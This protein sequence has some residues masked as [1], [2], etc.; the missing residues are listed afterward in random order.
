M[1]EEKRSSLK[2]SR[3][4][5]DLVAIGVGFVW[6]GFAG[7]VL[8]TGYFYDDLALLITDASLY[9]KL[10]DISTILLLLFGLLLIVSPLH[11]KFFGSI[12]TVFS[13]F[14]I[15][16]DIYLCTKEPLP[17]Y[18]SLRAHV[19]TKSIFF[20]SLLLPPLLTLLYSFRNTADQGKKMH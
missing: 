16:L 14:I 6:G 13:G 19:I 12:A 2:K 5:V 15:L 8:V 7:V 10:V 4:L 3:L 9:Y 17:S 11:R 1:Q 18:I 20:L